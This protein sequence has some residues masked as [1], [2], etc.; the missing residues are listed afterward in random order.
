MKHP[1]VRVAGTLPLLLG[2]TAADCITD[3][4]ASVARSGRVTA[5][6]DT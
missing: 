5:L 6:E 4:T 3:Q 1:A 2:A